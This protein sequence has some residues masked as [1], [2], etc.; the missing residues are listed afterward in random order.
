MKTIAIAAVLA[1]TPR[2]FSTNASARDYYSGYGY[3]YRGSCGNYD[4]L[5]S[6]YSRLQRDY[7]AAPTRIAGAGLSEKH[8]AAAAEQFSTAD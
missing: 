2:A 3:G 4:R 7:D 6:D 1:L 5:Q 8:A